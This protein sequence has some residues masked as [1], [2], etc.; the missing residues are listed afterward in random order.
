VCKRHQ[1]EDERRGQIRGPI[2]RDG[3]QSWDD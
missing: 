3:Y 2:L 1:A